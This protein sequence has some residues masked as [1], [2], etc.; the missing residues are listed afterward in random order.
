[1][2]ARARVRVAGR[3]QGVFYRAETQREARSI[4]VSGWVRNTRDG[5][6]EAVFEGDRESIREAIE[7]C[8]TGPP[9]A[10]VE[11]VDV[12]WEEPLGEKGFQVRYE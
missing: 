3:V 12:T 6:V 5:S 10:Q 7:W 4:G 11:S 8:R 1:M 2:T 9:A